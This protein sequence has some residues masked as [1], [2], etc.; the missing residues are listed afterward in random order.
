MR[1]VPVNKITEDSPYW[2]RHWRSLDAYIAREG[3]EERLKAE[4]TARLVEAKKTVPIT[5]E[6][7]RQKK[8]V[9]DT[10]KR[11]SD[12]CSKQHKIGKM[13]GSDTVAHPNQVANK[14]YLPEDGLCEQETVYSLALRLYDLEFLYQHGELTMQ[15]WDFLRWRIGQA[16]I[17]RSRHKLP[18][19]QRKSAKRV[20]TNMIDKHNSDDKMLRMMTVFAY[21][22]KQ[23]SG[24]TFGRTRETRPYYNNGVNQVQEQI[25]ERQERIAFRDQINR[26]SQQTYDMNVGGRKARDER[27]K[28]LREEA[29]QAAREKELER[30]KKRIRLAQQS[31]YGGVNAYRQQRSGQGGT[32]SNGGPCGS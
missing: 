32:A 7:K 2:D 10:A 27:A 30:R 31:T 28:K 18:D 12:N 20:I 3:E 24:R 25:N 19:E 13:F 16:A 22:I 17:R 11:H 4:W 21:Q 1:G 15:P 23:P 9:A 6:Q 5:A 29:E 26:R 14:R 8:L